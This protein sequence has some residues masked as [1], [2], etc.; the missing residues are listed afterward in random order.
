M[1]QDIP[2]ALLELG[3]LTPTASKAEIKRAYARKLKTLDAVADRHEFQHLR[4]IY[5]MALRLVALQEREAAEGAD[6][7]LANDP[8]GTANTR[9]TEAAAEH[10]IARPPADLEHEAKLQQAINAPNDKARQELLHALLQQMD[11][12]SFAMGERL[13]YVIAG[14]LAALIRTDDSGLPIFSPVVTRD[15]LD[16]CDQAFDWSSDTQSLNRSFGVNSPAVIAYL[17]RFPSVETR[18]AHAEAAAKRETR[19]KDF[20]VVVIQT[21]AL[22]AI[23]LAGQ[24]LNYKPGDIM[25]IAVAAVL[26]ILFGMRAFRAIRKRLSPHTPNRSRNR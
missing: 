13:Q 24:F 4:E 3:I 2:Y 14:H 9:E 25:V 15:F 12:L 21:L 19:R 22:I 18:R 7:S 5:E 8:A 10:E 1:P 6:A 17:A 23:A 20:R 11:T 16:E 26:L